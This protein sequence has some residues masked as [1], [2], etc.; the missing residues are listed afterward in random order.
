MKGVEIPTLFYSSRSN[1]H[2]F[3]QLA[4]QPLSVPLASSLGH[5]DS[6]WAAPPQDKYSLGSTLSRRQILWESCH[7]FLLQL[8]LEHRAPVPHP[9]WSLRAR[10]PSPCS[11]EPSV[12]T[13]TP[14]CP[15]CTSK[16]NKIPDQPGVP[17]LHLCLV[18]FDP[19]M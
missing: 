19:M 8:F 18:D 2:S 16:D 10:P 7:G 13:R 12:A 4:R 11:R 1:A 15:W 14:T 6:D 5:K 3:S 17:R 9:S